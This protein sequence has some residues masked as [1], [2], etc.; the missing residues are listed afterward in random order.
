MTWRSKSSSDADMCI[1]TFRCTKLSM[2][3][4]S[5]KGSRFRA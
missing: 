5:C 2:I 4:A 3:A 1:A